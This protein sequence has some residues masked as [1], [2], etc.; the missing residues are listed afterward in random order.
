MRFAHHAIL[1]LTEALLLVASIPWHA[2]DA[3][4]DEQ[5]QFSC[6]EM[7]RL[8]HAVLCCC[9]YAMIMIGQTVKIDLLMMRQCAVIG[10]TERKADS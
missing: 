4:A 2:N 8:Q 7:R 9:S 10:R 1:Q 6:S 3:A 5:L